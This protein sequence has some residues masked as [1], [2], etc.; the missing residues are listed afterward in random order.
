MRMKTAIGKTLLEFIA[1]GLFA[2][3]G[4]ICAWLCATKETYIL[5]GLIG[6]F[7]VVPISSTLGVW[8]V[9]RLLYRSRRTHFLYLLVAFLLS[10]IGLALLEITPLDTID[11]HILIFM[12]SVAACCSLIGYNTDKLLA[13]LLKKPT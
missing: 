1:A 9:D 10:M 7:L 13:F 3:A 12:P 11:E 2:L 8:I 5:V 4:F 6:K